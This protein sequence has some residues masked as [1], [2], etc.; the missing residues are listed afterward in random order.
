M[1]LWQIVLIFSISEELQVQIFNL[2]ILTG[3]WLVWEQKIEKDKPQRITK[4]TFF[5]AI[6]IISATLIN[7]IYV[8][9][10]KDIF[11][12][13]TIPFLNFGLILLYEGA[14]HCKTKLGLFLLSSLVPLKEIFLIPLEK[15]LPQFAS[16]MTWFF[17][18]MI[19]INA[20]MTNNLIFFEKKGISVVDGC[21]GAEQIIF[22]ISLLMIF[23]VLYPLRKRIHFYIL[24]SLTIII[25]FVENCIRLTLLFLIN[26]SD[27]LQAENLF[28]FFHNS[29]GS[30]IFTSLTCFIISKSYFE[31]IKREIR[32]LK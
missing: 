19:G 7:G 17:L 24:I 15:L 1:L 32:F 25:S 31:F 4:K 30:L 20:N 23:Y 16:N 11:F 2:L 13:L 12:Y 10:V 18:K 6:G 26:S 29:Y 9:S 27:G 22:A 8:D 5:S 28:D 3:L 21:S 14:M